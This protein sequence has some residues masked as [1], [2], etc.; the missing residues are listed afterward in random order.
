MNELSRTDRFGDASS[1]RLS[2][3]RDDI[4]EEAQQFIGL[5]RDEARSAIIDWFKD[6]NLLEDVKP[7]NHSVGHSYR[8][9]VPIEP[10]LSS[11]WYVA[12]TDDRLRGS[13]LRAQNVEQCPLSLIHI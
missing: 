3:G 1:C 8:S 4:S 6:N 12:V 9:H 10:W 11:Q 13:A 2:L 7:Y 5:Y